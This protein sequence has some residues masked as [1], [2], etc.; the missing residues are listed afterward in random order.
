MLSA[1]FLAIFST[2]AG[3]YFYGNSFLMIILM[4]WAVQYPHDSFSLLTINLNSIYFPLMYSGLMV[5]LG[6]SFKNYLAGFMIGLLLG[7]TKNPFF[8]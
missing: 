4:I 6:S 7:I 8:I 3:L 2:F 1:I 5:L